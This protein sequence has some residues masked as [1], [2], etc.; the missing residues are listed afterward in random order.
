M[1]PRGLASGSSL[2]RLKQN[3]EFG[4]IDVLKKMEK[5]NTKYI[6]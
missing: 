6:S 1:I 2:R 3:T 5:S 4:V